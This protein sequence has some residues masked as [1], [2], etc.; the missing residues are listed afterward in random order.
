MLTKGCLGGCGACILGD[1]QKPLDLAAGSGWSCEGQAG[2]SAEVPFLPHH[3]VILCKA[4]G[5]VYQ[6]ELHPSNYRWVQGVS[7][8]GC[9]RFQSSTWKH[10]ASPDYKARMCRLEMSY[11]LSEVLFHCALLLEMGFDRGSSLQ[12]G[13]LA[14]PQV[15]WWQCPY[16]RDR[17]SASIPCGLVWALQRT[18]N[19]STTCLA[20]FLPH[21]N[22]VQCCSWPSS[23]LIISAIPVMSPGEIWTADTM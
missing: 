10:E 22:T 1:V 19:S 15:G 12:G 20:H 23:G 6:R 4:K 9:L 17:L 21:W 18:Q 14:A 13:N 3:S 11:R 2:W 5:S 7:G 8:R 16:L